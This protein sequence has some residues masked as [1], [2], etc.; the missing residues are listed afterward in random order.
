M[1]FYQELTMTWLI[2][3]FSFPKTF[4]PRYFTCQ[5]SFLS[6]YGC[7][8]VQFGLFVWFSKLVGQ[9]V[10]YSGL[11]CQFVGWLVGCLVCLAC[12]FFQ[13]VKSDHPIPR[14]GCLKG[15][16]TVTTVVKK[17][18]CEKLPKRR[19]I[20]TKLLCSPPL[21]PCQPARIQTQHYDYLKSRKSVAFSRVLPSAS[22]ARLRSGRSYSP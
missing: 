17:T 6:K 22:Q 2:W 21:P 3:V 13:A 9:L 16:P 4:I 10:W 20:G 18:D 11:V 1:G 12:V 8:V 19:Q 15:K 7:L 14:Q 5:E